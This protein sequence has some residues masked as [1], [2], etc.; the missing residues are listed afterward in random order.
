MTVLPSFAGTAITRRSRRLAAA[1]RPRCRSSC[2]AS[3]RTK[4]ASAAR[5]ASRLRKR[6][7]VA[8]IMT[9]AARPAPSS[10]LTAMPRPE[11]R[12]RARS[13][14]PSA[15]VLTN[16]RAPNALH[17]LGAE[18]AGAGDVPGMLRA[19]RAQPRRRL[20]ALRRQAL[21]AAK[22]R[23]A[24]RQRA[25]RQ[26][27]GRHRAAVDRADILRQ[28]RA[29]QAFQ[30]GLD[31]ALHRMRRLDIAAGVGVHRAGGAEKAGVLA[32]AVVVQRAGLR[33][34][35]APAPAPTAD[36]SANARRT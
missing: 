32:G 20:G 18:P 17:D 2:A 8:A 16:T 11:L 7:S 26:R 36:G 30:R 3:G 12:Q 21:P 29:G 23:E 22:A 5:S 9:S 27:P 19:G 14:T 6:A 10:H 34:R 35:R 1:R 33:R 24:A 15:P 4:R 28:R 25:E 31:L 13:S